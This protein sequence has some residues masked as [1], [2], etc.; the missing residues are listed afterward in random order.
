MQRSSQKEKRSLTRQ[1]FVLLV[2]A[3]AEQVQRWP[4]NLTDAEWLNIEAPVTVDKVKMLIK[5]GVAEPKQFPAPMPAM[6]HLSD[7]QVNAIAAY[8]ISLGA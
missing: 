5:G 2:T 7:D 8:V 4:P 3:L 6:G 1:P